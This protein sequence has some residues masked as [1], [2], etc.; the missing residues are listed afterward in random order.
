[1]RIADLR[2][3]I[4]DLWRFSNLRSAIRS[5]FKGNRLAV[6][7]GQRVHGSFL[8]SLFLVATPSAGK[9][10]AGNLSGHFEALAVIGAFLVEQ[11]YNLPGLGQIALTAVRQSDYPIVQAVALYTTLAFLVVNLV[12]DLAQMLL[13]VR[14][15]AA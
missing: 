6:D 4:S 8:L 14:V 11:V 5:R 15:E 7:V 13:D 1:M 2:L 10:A 3:Q 9:G 12:V